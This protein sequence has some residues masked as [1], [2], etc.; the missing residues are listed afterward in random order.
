M[1]DILLIQPPIRDFYLTAKRTIP[2]G[3]ACIASALIRD[4]FSVEIM[5]ALATSRSRGIPLPDEMAYLGEFYGKPDVSPFALF[6][7][8]KHFGAGFERIGHAAR[9]SG[10]FLV[11]ISSLF[12]AYSEEALETARIVRS[13]HPTCKIVMGG[14]HPTEMPERVME[15]EAV[16]YVI[17]GEGEVS[18]PALAKA[19]KEGSGIEAVPGLVRRL[20]DGSIG[21]PPPALMENPGDYP[22]PAV[23]LLNQRFYRRGQR[24]GAV[25][26]ASRGCP[27]RCTYCSVGASSY[28]R[29][30]RRTVESVLREIEQAVVHH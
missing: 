12:T 23:H 6:H 10:A 21:S 1:P 15:C 29:Y 18:L 26:V 22:L 13:F 2:Y 20:A 4:G 24:P 25:I 30:R 27:L 19:L 7:H 14:H 11:G 28:L 5:D 3:L 17:R 9:D 8:F 16:D